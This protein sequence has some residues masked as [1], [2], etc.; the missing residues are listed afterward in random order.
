M[1]ADVTS[2]SCR[3]VWAAILQPS[4]LLIRYKMGLIYIPYEF[5]LLLIFTLLIVIIRINRNKNETHKLLFITKGILLSSSIIYILSFIGI[6]F[7]VLPPIKPIYITAIYW[8]VIVRLILIL[9]FVVLLV[10][11]IN[12]ES[13]KLLKFVWTIFILFNGLHILRLTYSYLTWTKPAI[14]YD[15]PLLKE[16]FS[17]TYD[18]SLQKYLTYI[19]PPLLW[20]IISVIAVKKLS[21]KDSPNTN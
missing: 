12:K 7:T 19:I 18:H 2:S 8:Y 10:L 16:V 6:D 5:T 9:L 15:D 20:I 17:H 11:F 13:K 4:N 21:T 1:P 3:R 14:T